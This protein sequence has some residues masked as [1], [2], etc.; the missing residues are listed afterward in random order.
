MKSTLDCSA[1]RTRRRNEKRSGHR[2][3][4]IVCYP[5]N[6]HSRE[7]LREG[8][9][10]DFVIVNFN[11]LGH[12]PSVLF[13]AMGKAKGGEGD[14]VVGWI[15]LLNQREE[16]AQAREVDDAGTK[17]VLLGHEWEDEGDVR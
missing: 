9:F 6:E 15:W 5:V 12:V 7:R 11:E 8:R 14:E 13:F 10:G 4:E 3:E 1:R 17:D 2:I 16:S